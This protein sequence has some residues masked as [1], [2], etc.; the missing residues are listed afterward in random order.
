MTTEN[1]NKYERIGNVRSI[2]KKEFANSIPFPILE[3]D[4]KLEKTLEERFSNSPIFFNT[5]FDKNHLKTVIGWFLEQY[6][7]KVTVDLVETLKQVGFHQATR[8]GVSLGIEDLQIPPPK[9]TLLS[10]ASVKM[11]DV[12]AAIQKGNLTGVEKSQRLIDTWNQTSENLRQS[13]VQHFRTTNPVNPVY[14]MAFSGARGNISQVRQLVAMRGL[15]ADPQ[16][17]ILEFPIRSNFREGLTI[18]EYLLSCY[19]ARKGL[20]DTALRTATSGYLTRRLV[21]AVQ[22]VVVHINDCGTREGFLIKDKN[23]EQRLIGR[24]LFQDVVLDEKTSL[25][26]NTLISSK[27]AKQIASKYKQIVVR[28]PLTCETEKSVCQLCYGLDLAQGKLVSIGEAVGIIAAQSIGEPGTQLTMR[29]FH[30]GGVGVFSDQSMKSFTAPFASKVEFLEPLAGLFVRT[31]HG[32]IVYL[33]KQKL[34][35]SK[36]PILRLTCLSEIPKFWNQN[37]VFSK[38]NQLLEK[39][40]SPVYE[41]MQNEILPGSFLWVKQGEYVKNGQLLLQSPRIETVKQEMPES[42]HPVHAPLSGEIFFQSMTLEKIEEQKRFDDKQH[43]KQQQKKVAIQMREKEVVPTFETLTRLGNFWIFSSYIQKEIQCSQSFLRKGD[44]ISPHTPI[45]QANLHILSPE[46][47]EF[48]ISKLK[49]LHS[50]LVVGHEWFEFLVSKS[51]YAGKFYYFKKQDHQLKKDSVLSSTNNSQHSI[52]SYY[53][54]FNTRPGPFLGYYS[55]VSVLPSSKLSGSV[56]PFTNLSKGKIANKVK[57]KFAL[58]PSVNSKIMG[59]TKQSGSGK[60]HFREDEILLKTHGK[61]L[62]DNEQFVFHEQKSYVWSPHTL[63]KLKTNISFVQKLFPVVPQSSFLISQSSHALSK[64]G[65]FQ[66]HPHKKITWQKKKRFEFRF[67]K[68]SNSSSQLLAILNSLSSV[69]VPNFGKTKFIQNS[70]NIT[71]TSSSIELKVSNQNLGER[72]NIFSKKDSVHVESKTK[73]LLSFKD[74]SSTFEKS[75]RNKSLLTFTPKIIQKQKSWPFFPN[76][77]IEKNLS[78]QLSGTLLEPGKRFENLRFDH[79]YISLNVLNFENIIFVKEKNFPRASFYRH[80]DLLNSNKHFFSKRSSTDIRNLFT[81]NNNSTKLDKNQEEQEKQFQINYLANLKNVGPARKCFN[82]FCFYKKQ[83]TET[84]TIFLT[85]R[86]KRFSHLILVQKSSYQIVDSANL[87]QTNWLFQKPIPLLPSIRSPL[88]TKQQQTIFTR[89]QFSKPTVTFL[90]PSQSDWGSAIRLFKVSLKFTVPQN[91]NKTEHFRQRKSFVNNQC[92][93]IEIPSF[94]LFIYDHVQFKNKKEFDFLTFQNSFI[95][96]NFKMAEAFLTAQK[97]GEFRGGYE[98]RNE[99]RFSILRNQDCSTLQLE[100][101]PEFVDIQVGKNTRWGQELVPDS[102]ILISGRVVKTTKQS[103]KIRKGFPILASRRGLVHISQNQLVEK[104][105]LLITLRSRRLQTE[106]IVQG[107]PKIEQL[108]EARETQGGEIIKDNMHI[109]L[110]NFFIRACAVRPINQAVEI[111]LRY[112]QKFLVETILE[113]YSNQGVSIA[114][115]HVEVV[116]RQ[117]TARVRI[118]YGGDT[119]LLPGEFVQLR[120]IQKLNQ[121]LEKIGLREAT[122]EPMILGITKSVLQSE[123]FLLAVSF[124]QVSQV[125]VRSALANKTDF[126]RGLHENL[127]VG[128]P[129]PAGTGMIQFVGTPKQDQRLYSPP[130]TPNVQL[131]DVH[132]SS[133][134]EKNAER[135]F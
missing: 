6:G 75:F 46:I 71:L 13:A 123:S 119:G 122:Y 81:E 120:W 117:M 102:A 55:L 61:S 48:G 128:Q 62:D 59:E 29:T 28:S 78:S 58:Q 23:L 60:R 95:L 14:M 16:G 69:A 107:I 96:P 47:E 127:I 113:A 57:T 109:L 45:H 38:P 67:L 131:S 53:P 124:Q 105:D 76:T 30:T 3:K 118:T 104:H 108:F 116:V 21:E 66:I 88:F 89:K 32:N 90:S 83:R 19:G 121:G 40:H 135:E 129:M 93:L 4:I 100:K 33:I 39:G 37:E 8:A 84:N 97:L 5:C 41:I 25:I 10:Q 112:I 85:K 27:L 72:T 134:F 87:V 36:K 18:T 103:V 1:K 92:K 101:Q 91:L 94:S 11:T 77:V 111:S 50:S 15:M 35:E 63:F 115:K 31:P 114:E 52:L 2:T 12:T 54:F 110:K 22:H 26:K 34:S 106:D 7:E 17:A 133:L 42:S 130:E 64:S 126:L 51:Y 65:I 56:V 70:S 99:F 68:N 125:L 24:V 132:K 74:F 79:C 43:K 73:L 98:K 82:K 86:N 49:T 20:V 80:Q 9:H 44:L